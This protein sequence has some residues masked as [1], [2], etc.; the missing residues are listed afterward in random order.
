M[1][2][3]NFSQ[4]NQNTGNQ[5]NSSRNDGPQV[6]FFSLKNHGDEAIVR[7]MHDTVDSF[8][9]VAVH[10]VEINGRY[11]NVNCLRDPREPLDNC[12]MCANGTPI[13]QKFYIHLLQYN[14]DNQGNIIVEPCIWERSATYATTIAN[15]I[16]E[17]GPLS[18][19]I[20]K[21]RRNGQAGSMETTYDIMY[22]HPNVYKNE[23]YP[24]QPELFNGY[25]VIGRAVLDK[26]P[27]EMR[28]YIQT[29]NF[30]M[31]NNQGNNNPPAAPVQGEQ[32]P[33][34]EAPRAN[35]SYNPSFNDGSSA[36]RNWGNTP[37][38]PKSFGAPNDGTAPVKAGPRYY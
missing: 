33:I 10:P 1:A 21:I 22:G 32:I 30:P 18:D 16:N 23:I 38:Q 4:I 8:D 29:G 2:Q 19:H 6:R 35:P 17:Y 13:R 12:P 24:K 14:R 37:A 28:A 31:N 5:N 11:R 36:V 34:P 26:N 3:I 25:N 20:F 27:D 9:L 7:I 15:L